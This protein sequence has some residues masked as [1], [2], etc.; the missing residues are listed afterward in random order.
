[1]KRVRLLP[2]S[3]YFLAVDGNTLRLVNEDLEEGVA[4][5]YDLKLSK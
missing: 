3:Y 2:D 1:M 4:G 5:N